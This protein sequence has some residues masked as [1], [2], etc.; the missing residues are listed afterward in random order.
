MEAED[1]VVSLIAL[2]DRKVI[3]R[4][5]IQKSA[6][7]LDRCGG[8]FGLSF[9]YYHYG[10]YSFDLADGWANACVNKRISILERYSQRHG[11][12]YSIFKLSKNEKLPDR[13]GALSTTAAR[14]PLKAMKEVSDIVL[15]L[16][17]T[18]VFLR[19]QGEYGDRAVQET[20][21]RKPVKAIDV[22]LQDAISLIRNLGLDQKK[23]LAL[24]G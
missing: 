13:I 12:P 2:H 6:Y 3:G 15:E 24:P 17:A 4:T 22:R 16:A 8:D 1:I 9:V 11:V 23:A 14:S 20:K 10:P 18:I 5:R 21:D 19:D 7:L